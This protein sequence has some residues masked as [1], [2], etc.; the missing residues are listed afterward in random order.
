MSV[1]KYCCFHQF[2]LESTGVLLANKGDK[3][4]CKEYSEK[5]VN[6][7]NEVDGFHPRSWVKLLGMIS[8][9]LNEFSPSRTKVYLDLLSTH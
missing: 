5:T 1:L 8:E 7:E 9:K 3:T 2:F 4:S 6:T